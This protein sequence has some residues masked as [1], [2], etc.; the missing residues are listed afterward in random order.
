MD[1]SN[2]PMRDTPAHGR[3][4]PNPATKLAFSPA[5]HKGAWPHAAMRVL[6]LAG[7]SVFVCSCGKSDRL[8]VYPTS[9]TVLQGDKPAIGAIVILHPEGEARPGLI[10]PRGKVGPDGVFHLTTYESGDGAPDGK[11]IVTLYWPAPRPPDAPDL[12]DGP[13]RLKGR[14]LNPASPLTH[15]TIPNEKSQLA[16]L[17]IP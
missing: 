16:P 13:C 8:P 6:L 12:D 2:T 4:A 17:Q 11:Y 9:G 14:F 15:L 3:N 10:K 5:Q 1:S 7:L